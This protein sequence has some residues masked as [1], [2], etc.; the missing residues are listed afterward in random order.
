MS[1]EYVPMSDSIWDTVSN[2]LTKS[3][4]NMC[5]CWIEK[6]NNIPL[7]NKYMLQ[8]ESLI[9]KRG[10]KNIFEKQLF[11]GTKYNFV[12]NI[13]DEGFKVDMNRISAYGKGT[14]FST[15]A[16]M[17]SGYTDKANNEMSYIIVCK[18]LVGKYKIGVNNETVNTDLYDNTVNNLKNPTIITSPYDNGAYPE[19]VVAY[20]KNAK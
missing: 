14:Y 12:D 15:S 10:E 8:K 3:F 5:I 1:R 11:H 7:Y 16:Q 9:Q 4:P 17:S 13:C 2:I 20:Y 19:Y 6:N 18:V